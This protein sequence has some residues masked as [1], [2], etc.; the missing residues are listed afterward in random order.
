LLE[1][2]REP[3][4]FAMRV[5]MTGR[6]TYGEAVREFRGG[7]LVLTETR[8]AAA[9]TLRRHDHEHPNVNVVLSGAF[10]ETVERHHYNC[11]AQSALVKPG[12]SQHSDRYGDKPAH[13]IVVEFT[14]DH[15][16]VN[17]EVDPLLAEHLQR[18]SGPI[19]L[20]AQQLYAEL[21]AADVSTSLIV[22]GL[23]LQ[24]LGAIVRAGGVQERNRRPPAWAVR[25]RD[26]IEANLNAALRLSDLAHL[27]GVHAT[28]LNRTFKRY[29]GATI[30]TYTRGARL[31]SAV[32]LLTDGSDSLA[33]VAAQTG[34]CDQSHFA[35][36]FKRRFGVTP[37]AF[38]RARG[39][40]R[41]A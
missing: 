8:H 40:G 34:F 41:P 37:G 9:L 23:S 21:Y 19:G 7:G 38:R 5:A 15:T 18:R 32:Q 4:A 1:K 13:C 30:G 16:S 6:V 26:M 39:R 31:R 24:L 28:H 11:D 12:G 36:A 17:P 27:A 20:I 35:A 29:F 10:R 14:S 3:D 22:E 33:S 25:T 2:Q